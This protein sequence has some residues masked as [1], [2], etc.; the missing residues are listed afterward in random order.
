M[1]IR[2]DTTANLRD[3]SATFLTGIA[4]IEGGAGDDTL[5]G[6]TGRDVLSGGAGRDVMT[7]GL[8][9]DTFVFASASDSVK[10]TPDLITD[11][12]SG[13]DHVDLSLIDANTL[14]TGDQAFAF[15]SSALFSHTAGELRLAGGGVGFAQLVGDVNGDGQADFM[16]KF[17]L[18]TGQMS[19]VTDFIL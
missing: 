3:F 8:G 13:V 14:L 11:F 6:S 2:G 12:V 7:G 9:A 4:R 1:V 15:I 17:D 5:I 18:S 10:A 19:V 16:L